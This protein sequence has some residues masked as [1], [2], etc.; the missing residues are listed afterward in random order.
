M[1]KSLIEEKHLDT[2]FAIASYFGVS[3]Q[4]AD[5]RRESLSD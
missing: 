4:A 5:I 3:L 1:P 2:T